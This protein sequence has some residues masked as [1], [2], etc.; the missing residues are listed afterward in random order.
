M[1]LFTDGP[2]SSAQDLQ[3]Y[4]ASVL[5]IANSEGIDVAA[6][7]MLA[8][9]DLGNEVSVFLLRRGSFRDYRSIITR[10]YE[11]ADVV[12]NDALRQWHI[13]KTLAMVY[14]DAYN[15]QLNDRYR[16]KW[17]EYEQL[18]KLSARA[19]LQLGLGVVADPIARASAPQVLSVSGPGEAATFYVVAT[20]VNGTGEEGDPSDC[21]QCTTVTGTVITVSL[22]GAPQNAV[23]WNVYVGLTPNALTRQ[24]DTPLEVS[25]S[26]SM[27]GGLISGAP[28]GTGQLPSWF[29]VDRHVMERG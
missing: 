29:V 16:G 12:V 10:A 28:L 9:R 23:G 20:W 5:S 14:R 8:Q 6:K 24:N 13:H 18:V 3:Q 22:N 25:S 15:N 19:C 21:A 2:I 1:A 4:D 27:S 11:L 17:N 7:A 26:W